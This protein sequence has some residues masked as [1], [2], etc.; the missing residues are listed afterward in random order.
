MKSFSAASMRA[1]GFFQIVEEISTFWKPGSQT[2]ASVKDAL[3]RVAP[4]AVIPA[5]PDGSVQLGGH[6]G[7]VLS[8]ALLDQ[9]CSV[10]GESGIHISFGVDEGVPLRVL[11]QTHHGEI[12]DHGLVSD[13]SLAKEVAL[14]CRDVGRQH[15]WIV[16][17]AD[18]C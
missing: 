9:V 11:S 8:Q 12:E 14:Y 1:L 2:P 16:S 18:L 17:A 3:T 6:L 13:F 5:A 15:A 4:D 7:D 10:E